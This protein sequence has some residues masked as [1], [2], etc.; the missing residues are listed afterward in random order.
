MRLDLFSHEVQTL[1]PAIISCG[2]ISTSKLECLLFYAWL[3]LGVCLVKGRFVVSCHVFETFWEQASPERLSLKIEWLLSPLA[4]ID[5][6]ISPGFTPSCGECQFCQLCTGNSITHCS[7]CINAVVCLSFRQ[8]FLNW[9][10][11]RGC[12]SSVAKLC[13]ILCDPMACYV[14]SSPVLYYLLKFA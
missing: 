11:Y 7:L 1:V 4:R 6:Q 8:A 5:C 9:Q 2:N 13:L 12:Y 3:H 14:P 10:A